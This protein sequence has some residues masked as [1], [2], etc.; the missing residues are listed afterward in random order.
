MMNIKFLYTYCKEILHRKA[1]PYKING[2]A[3]IIYIFWHKI[4]GQYPD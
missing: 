3:S 2:S 4:G 1:E